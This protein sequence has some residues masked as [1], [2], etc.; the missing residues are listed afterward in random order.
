MLCQ[1]TN[2][3][4]FEVCHTFQTCRVASSPRGGEVKVV[5]RHY[6]LHT[7]DRDVKLDGCYS[8]KFLRSSARRFLLEILSEA[9][10][11]K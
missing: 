10:G 5:K 6:T 8:S 9:R 4:V 11:T 7:R 1:T 3:K 2:D